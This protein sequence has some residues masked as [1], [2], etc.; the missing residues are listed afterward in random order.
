MK[1]SSRIPRK[2]VKFIIVALAILLVVITFS[3][4]IVQPG[5]IYPR[6]FSMPYSLWTSMV[7]S[8]ILV[9]LTYLASKVQDKD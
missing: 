7:I 2:S 6:L 9:I 3:P 4:L 5:K 8:I 1:D